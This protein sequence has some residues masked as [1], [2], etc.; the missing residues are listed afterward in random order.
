[1][2]L[3]RL[4]VRIENINLFYKLAFMKIFQVLYQMKAGEVVTS[5]PTIGLN[6]E[7]IKVQNYEIMA[8]DIG[9]RSMGN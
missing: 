6:I 4:Q 7:S 1:M 8:W 3:E 5:I 2:L 9:G